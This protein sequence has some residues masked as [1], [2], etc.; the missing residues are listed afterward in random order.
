MERKWIFPAPDLALVRQLQ[1]RLRVSPVTARLLVNRGLTEFS[2]ARAF[3]EP[4]LHNL[5][6]PRDHEALKEAADFLFSAAKEGKQV[7]VYGDY[8]A[9]GI[10]ATAILV[11][12]LK[13]LGA[14]VDYYIPRRLEEGYGLN[15]DALSEIKS[16]GTDVVVTVDCGISARKE[17][18]KASEFGLDLIITDH[19]ELKGELPNARAILNPHLGQCEFGYEGLAGVGVAYKLIWALGQRLAGGGTMPED[20][21]EHLMEMLPLVAI[22]TVAD[23]VPLVDENRILT[24]FG[25]RILPQSRIPGLQALM[26][27]ARIAGKSNLTTYHIGFQLAPRL[28]AAG[29]VADARAAVDMFVTDNPREAS[30]TAEHLQKQNRKRQSIQRLA[31]EQAQELVE[32]QYDPEQIGCLMLSSEEWHPGV[33]GLVASRLAERFW[34]PTFVFHEEEDLA[35][36]SARS[37]PGFHLFNAIA[38]C[39]ELLVRFGGH[40]GAAGLTLPLE[41][42]DTF[43][44]KMNALARKK[45]GDEPPIP[46]LELE[47]EIGLQQLTRPA[48]EEFKVLSPFGEGNPDPL[49]AAT[50]L[51]V[52]GNPK[53]VGSHR[54][55]LSFK[56]RQNDATLKVIA[57]RKAD[58]LKPLQ[59]RSD[60]PFCLAFEPIINSFNG[61]VNVELRAEDIQWADQELVEV[62]GGKTDTTA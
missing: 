50:D 38:D 43:R 33:V 55:H 11:R 54:N 44:E 61:H 16:S 42:L 7:T 9:D 31:T 32:A 25:L 37:I 27:V 1:D 12:S 15:C 48:V 8:D 23:I 18:K 62:R 24:R 13:I 56:V 29:R 14:E 45:L 4:S 21:R 35:R 60:E 19:H 53:L 46:Q 47:G 17:A 49:F 30:E 2:D 34:R 51:K 59:E 22:G 57:F 40:E 58:W 39:E 26:E 36:G 10:C 3:L 20:Y 41:K 5:R 28:N 52:V 6:D